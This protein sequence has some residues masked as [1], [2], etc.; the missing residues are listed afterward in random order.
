MDI[1]E[2]PL[3]LLEEERRRGEQVQQISGPGLEVLIL[4]TEL[5]SSWRLTHYFLPILLF[6]L[7]WLIPHWAG[8]RLARSQR[9]VVE[10]WKIVCLGFW[11]NKKHSYFFSDQIGC[12]SFSVY[13]VSL[14]ELLEEDE[15]E[16]AWRHCARSCLWPH[17]Q[18]KKR[19]LVSA[20]L[21]QKPLSARPA[22]RNFA[23]KTVFSDI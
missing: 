22:V 6:L 5:P 12:W 16:K 3:L 14:A 15:V 21:E 20:W 1:V 10:N 7:R 13:P 18:P 23:W 19:R 4:K 2:C 9:N 17:H 8:F 11:Q